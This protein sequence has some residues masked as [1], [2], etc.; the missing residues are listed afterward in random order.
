MLSAAVLGHSISRY[1][2]AA[3]F[4]DDHVMAE[5]CAAVD[6]VLIHFP[7]MVDEEEKKRLEEVGWSLRPVERVYGP[8]D[9]EEPHR[10]VISPPTPSKTNPTAG[11]RNS[12]RST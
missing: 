3:A 9:A 6:M 5:K 12:A 8:K 1:R 4:E 7:G 11:I 10:H 2:N